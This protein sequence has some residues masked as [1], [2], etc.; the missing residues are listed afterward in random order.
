M[1]TLD[2]LIGQDRAVELLRAAVAADRLHHAWIFR[3]PEGVGKMTAA[4]AFAGLLLDPEAG[5]D[6]TGRFGVDPGSQTQRLL[7]AGAH[8]DFGVVTKELATQSRVDTVRR[9]K[10]RTIPKEVAVEFLVEP[11]A[12]APSMGGGLA[13]RVFV[14]DEAELL[15]REAQNAILKTLEEPPPGSVVILVTPREHALLPTIRSRCQRVAFAALDDGAMEGWLARAGVGEGVDRAWLLRF[16]SGS[17]GRATL[18]METGLLAWAERL[19]PSLRSLAGGAYD[20]GFAPTAAGLMGDWAG[21]W[22]KRAEKAGASPS[23]EAANHLAARHMF[24]LLASW[25]STRLRDLAA[26][27]AGD[28]GPALEAVDLVD[29][30]ERRSRA[31]VQP[32]FVLDDLAARLAGGAPAVSR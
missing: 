1:P 13:K 4:R 20:P 9:Q 19:A 25:A 16:A 18:A 26:Q 14:V 10:Q 32:L 24:G 31:N 15:S 7:A 8:P 11:I 27:G 22:V 29:E 3:G 2:D 30:A 17:P 5:P 23:K 28:L 21:E 12:L 6:L